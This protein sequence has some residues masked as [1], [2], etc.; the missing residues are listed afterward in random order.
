MTCKHLHEVTKIIKAEGLEVLNVQQQK[1]LK[2]T[3]SD[4]S[5]VFK[6]MA[7]TSPS[8]RNAL[9]AFRKRLLQLI[10]SYCDG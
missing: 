1:H 3:V 9:K 10:E 2:I 8:D 6:V 7:A 5:A 4:G